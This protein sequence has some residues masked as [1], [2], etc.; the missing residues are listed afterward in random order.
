MK[1]MPSKYCGIYI[2]R[3]RNAQNPPKYYWCVRES[4]P[5][6]ASL[7]GRHTY[8]DHFPPKNTKQ[9]AAV[10]ALA[11]ADVRPKYPRGARRRRAAPEGNQ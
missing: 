6:S 10:L 2:I 9:A 1:K 7:T 8:K 5:A 4:I 3:K 11:L